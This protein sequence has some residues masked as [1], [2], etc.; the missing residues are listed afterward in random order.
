M[1]KPGVLDDRFFQRD[2]KVMKT[3]L[4]RTI[5][6]GLTTLLLLAGCRSKGPEILKRTQFIMGTLVEIT[7]IAPDDEASAEA[8]TAAFQEMRRIEWLMSRR[9]EGSDVWRINHSAGDRGVRVSPDL[10]AVVRVALET[11]NLSDG[12]FDITV[13]GL[14][15][16]WDR[17]RKENR[18]P[19]QQEVTATRRLVGYGSLE[20]DEKERILFLKKEG[21]QIVLGGLAKGYAVDQAVHILQRRGF[22]NFIVNAGGDLR[23]GGTKLGAPWVVGIQDPRD[24]SRTVATIPTRDSVIATSGDY[25]RYFVKNGIRYHEIL[26]PFTGFPARKSRSVTVTHKELIWADALATAIFVMG[27]DRGIALVEGLADADVLIIDSNG[28]S[29]VSSGMRE[30][31]KSQ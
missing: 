10:F 19:S 1:G 9:I 29:H 24:K 5:F 8:V 15:N 2:S 12:A 31:I 14:V 3:R 27:P 28:K 6:F 13:G 22:K 30:R 20:L 23:T 21:M 7:L 25:E 18:L 11:S 26:N 16:L 4:N 17:C